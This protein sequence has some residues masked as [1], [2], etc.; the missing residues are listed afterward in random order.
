M[1]AP[2]SSQTAL[3][4][5]SSVGNV[6]VA[7]Q[8]SAQDGRR[9]A[10][11]AVT[12][13][14]HV[15]E[16]PLLAACCDH[17]QASETGEVASISSS[18]ADS[19]IEISRVQ[20]GMSPPLH[21]SFYLVSGDRSS[22]PIGFDDSAQAIEE[23]LRSLGLGAPTVTVSRDENSAPVVSATFEYSAAV[24]PS[25]SQ[26]EVVTDPDSSAA[27]ALEHDLVNTT[28]ADPD[29]FR[30]AFRGQL[31]APLPLNASA[32]AVSAAV[33]GLST[34]YAVAGVEEVAGASA[35][36]VTFSGMSQS[37]D[38]SPPGRA[39]HGRAECGPRPHDRRAGGRRGYRRLPLPGSGRCP[40]H[41]ARG[42]HRSGALACRAASP[43]GL[44]GRRAPKR[45]TRLSLGR[46]RRRGA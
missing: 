35:W 42:R 46:A 45:P 12:F 15:G 28:L 22:A 17:T 27:L 44:D 33:S 38:E 5:L 10:S 37:D 36:S 30:I 31:S 39:Q 3:E 43:P 26:L 24:Q 40:R 34:V 4:A 18:S 1:R 8:S 41:G 14:S 29:A 21:G 13:L 2:R 23:G 19:L 9:V 16:V 7:A 6:S 11:W 32:A 25:F 20:Q